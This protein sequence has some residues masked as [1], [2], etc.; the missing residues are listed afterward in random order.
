MLTATAL[1]FHSMP[2]KILGTVFGLA[3]W[4]VMYGYVYPMLGMMPSG[5]DN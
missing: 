5:G 2:E 3:F 4:A 1:Y